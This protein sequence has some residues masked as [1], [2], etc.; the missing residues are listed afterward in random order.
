MW[1][2]EVEP[3]LTPS[4][5]TSTLGKKRAYFLWPQ[6]VNICL[7]WVRVAGYGIIWGPKRAKPLWRHVATGPDAKIIYKK[8]KYPKRLS[9]CIGQAS[10]YVKVCMSI[11]PILQ[12]CQAEV[13]MLVVVLYVIGACVG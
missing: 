2:E 1:A 10:M 8:H 6:F 5:A 7:K 3:W 4:E 13:V 11:L 12:E 9:I